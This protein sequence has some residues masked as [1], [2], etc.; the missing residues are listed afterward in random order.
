VSIWIAAREVLMAPNDSE[1]WI[2]RRNIDRFKKQIETER[3]EGRRRELTRLLDAEI[4]KLRA[5]NNGS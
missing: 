1:R 2:I 4:A 3:D 5:N